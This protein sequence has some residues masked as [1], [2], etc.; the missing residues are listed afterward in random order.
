[1]SQQLA[2]H[3]EH[4]TVREVYSAYV[5]PRKDAR[6]Y[7]QSRVSPIEEGQV[8][9]QQCGGGRRIVRKRIGGV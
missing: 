6:V 9:Y 2:P 3:R 5:K 1:M 4:T 8:S 7:H